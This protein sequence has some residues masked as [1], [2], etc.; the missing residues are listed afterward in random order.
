MGGEYLLVFLLCCEIGVGE[1]GLFFIGLFFEFILQL[2]D[3]FISFL[4]ALLVPSGVFVE[5]LRKILL[6][7][8]LCFIHILY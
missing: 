2:E 1:T 4:L 8:F 5:L 7:V 3:Y 6:L